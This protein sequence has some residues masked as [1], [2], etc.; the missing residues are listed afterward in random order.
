MHCSRDPHAVET[1]CAV[2]VIPSETVKFSVR[3]MVYEQFL[4]FLWYIQYTA[5][6]QNCGF[7]L[8]VR[9]ILILS[10][11]CSFRQG[12]WVSHSVLMREIGGTTHR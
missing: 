12:V 8:I 9:T 11:E 7:Y 2:P 5:Q 6:K 3:N 1:L 4:V 10:E